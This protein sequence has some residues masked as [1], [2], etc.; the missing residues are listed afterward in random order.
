MV[1]TFSRPVKAFAIGCAVLFNILVF[2]FTYLNVVPF[3]DDGKIYESHFFGITF[4][5]KKYPRDPVL[6]YVIVH[7]IIIVPF[8]SIICSNYGCFFA[9]NNFSP[10]TKTPTVSESSQSDWKIDWDSNAKPTQMESFANFMTVH[11]NGEFTAQ[12]TIDSNLSDDHCPVC[13]CDWN[14]LIGDTQ[15]SFVVVLPCSH[16]ICLHCLVVTHEAYRLEDVATVC[17]L[18]REGLKFE[19]N[20]RNIAKTVIPLRFVTQIGKVSRILQYPGDEI[21]DATVGICVK[22]KMDISIV[23]SVL[24]MMRSMKP[25]AKPWKFEQEFRHALLERI[26]RSLAEGI[27]EN[28]DYWV[29]RGSG[30]M[31]AVEEWKERSVEAVIRC[32]IELYAKATNIREVNYPCIVL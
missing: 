6:Q 13:L 25:L 5:W 30:R 19:L 28:N 31:L 14:D 24:K 17:V 22:A 12:T 29:D 23:E 27:E 3:R 11:S 16:Q 21:A 26:H 10:L 7:M 18:C 4:D 8:V 9:D 2:V 32:E 1:M 20:A 15:K